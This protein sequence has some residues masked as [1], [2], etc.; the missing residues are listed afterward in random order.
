[1]IELRRIIVIH[2]LKR[3]GLSISAIA[4]KTGLD[5]KTVRHYLNQGLAGQVYGPRAP[6]PRLLEPFETYLAEPSPANFAWS[7]S[8]RRRTASGSDNGSTPLIPLLPPP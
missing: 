1:M 2:D 3:Q 5:R 4:R 7:L 6:R 8:S